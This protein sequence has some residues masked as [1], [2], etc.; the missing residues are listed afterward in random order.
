M[1]RLYPNKTN[2]VTMRVLWLY[3][4]FTLIS[5]ATFLIGY[6]LLPEG[7]LSEGPQA[8]S[9]HIVAAAPTF[10]SELLLTLLFNLGLVVMVVVIMNLNRIKGF[11]LG[12]L[13]PLTMGIVSGLIP[14]T[15]S[16]VASDLSDFT[17]R[18]A[19]ALGLSIGVCCS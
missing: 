10:A 6:Y 7:I 8:A 14:G 17:V 13:L 19:M 4:L 2:H 1:A 12:Y 18:E 15:N 5:N 3:G 11:P 16:F 9:A